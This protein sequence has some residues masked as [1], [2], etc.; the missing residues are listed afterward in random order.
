[1]HVRTT[2]NLSLLINKRVNMSF[3]VFM[4]Q[5]FIVVNLLGKHRTATENKK[6]PLL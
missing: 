6:G 1:M 2:S 3:K 4:I 5:P